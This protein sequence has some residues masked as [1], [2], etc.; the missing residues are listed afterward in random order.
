ML[1]TILNTHVWILHVWILATPERVQAPLSLTSPFA[2]QPWAA[3]IMGL[4]AGPVYVGASYFVES[5]LKVDDPLDAVAVHGFGGLFGVLLAATFAD[6]DH[7][8]VAYG[9]MAARTPGSYGALTLLFSSLLC[10]TW[11]GY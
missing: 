4:I 9:D 7:L 8:A 10:T 2:L 6:Q 3:I 11:R 5:I 1:S